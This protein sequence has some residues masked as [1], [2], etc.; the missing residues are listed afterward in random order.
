[1]QLTITNKIENSSLDSFIYGYLKGYIYNLFLISVNR[2]RLKPFDELFEIDSFDILKQAML[3]LVISKQG[4]N[5][6]N[7]KPNNLIK[8]EDNYIDYYINLITYGNREIK[9]Y[10]IILD[11]F[12]FIYNNINKIYGEWEN[13]GYTLLRP[14]TS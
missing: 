12:K 7:I 6:Y 11:L 5:T 4:H 3:N 2:L 9:G 14:V 13:N 10:P 8:V 1:M